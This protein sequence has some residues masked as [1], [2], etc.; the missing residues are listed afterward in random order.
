MK[1]DAILKLLDAAQVASQRTFAMGKNDP[2]IAAAIDAADKATT[3]FHVAAFV[4]CHGTKKLQNALYL[5]DT[6]LSYLAPYVE[7]TG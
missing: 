3:E 2:G 4:E 1:T 7:G 6:E 5:V